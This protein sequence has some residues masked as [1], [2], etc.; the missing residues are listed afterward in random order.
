MN[1]TLMKDY[2][3]KVINKY[4]FVK[5]VYFNY[6]DERVYLDLLVYSQ[7][8]RSD[9]DYLLECVDAVKFNKIVDKTIRE[10]LKQKGIFNYEEY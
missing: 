4:V 7:K 5:R 1:T 6:T 3:F 10:Y 9:I 2:A 8:H